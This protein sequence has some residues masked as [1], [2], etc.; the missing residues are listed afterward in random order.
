MPVIKNLR[1]I[2]PALRFLPLLVLM[3]YGL[4]RSVS[5]PPSD[6]AGYYYGGRALLH[7]QVLGAY[8]MTTLNDRI[9][10]DGF[11][12]V[13]VSYAPF[14]PFTSLVFAPFLVFPMAVAKI[15]FNILSIA[16]FLFSLDRL[17]RR[18]STPPYLILL[19]P[20]IF[21]IPLVNNLAFGQAYL[22]LFALLAEGWLA[23][24]KDRRTLAAA[25]WAAA[26]LFKLFPAFLF[27]FLLLRKKYRQFARLAIAC[28]LLLIVSLC[29]N[30]IDAWKYY[31]SV[32]MPRMGHGELNDSFTYI[33]QSAFMLLKRAF[34]Y[35][36]LLNPH[37]F[38][39]NAWLFTVSMSLFKAAVLSAAVRLTLRGKDEFFPFTVWIA[40]SMLVSPNGSSYSLILLLFPLLGLARRISPEGPPN[41]AVNGTLA[42]GIILLAV[43]CA[44]P[45][46]RF[47]RLPLLLQFP[48]L[49][50]V[51][52]FYG[53]LALRL[54]PAA[55]PALLFA[56][57]AMFLC[58]DIRGNLRRK[59][60][61][62]YVLSAESHLFICHYG[63]RDHRLVYTWRDDRGIHD[64]PTGILVS[65]MTAEGLT[66]RDNQIRFHDR[67]V[68]FSSD[69]KAQP[70]LV[71]GGEIWYLSD[72]NR[73]F[74]FYTL[75]KIT[76]AAVSRVGAPPAAAPPDVA[77]ICQAFQ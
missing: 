18:C 60:P 33:F 34:R 59:E 76:P 72:L 1:T 70:M 71:N 19:L 44:V 66:L 10:A 57:T 65:S 77:T 14:P 30:G 4:W 73:G 8:D 53:L 2:P 36:T 61:G 15:A 16:L 69:R 9:A 45:V 37:P 32:I 63:A 48:R 29:V 62:G 47:G 22:L 49:Y 11:S 64:Q 42:A 38:V 46:A 13:L 43:A 26:I 31:I 17:A 39:D 25:L 50:V 6:F 74:G 20:V 35:D 51:L 7:G 68:T 23:Y 54:R 3:G 12:G 28:T 21:L 41:R 75:R 27:V 56:L 52:L 40:A 24:R 58:L 5:A 67:Q 55:G